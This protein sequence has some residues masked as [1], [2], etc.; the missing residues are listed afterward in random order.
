MV[1]RSSG[2][3]EVG[4]LRDSALAGLVGMPYFSFPVRSPDRFPC[5]VILFLFPS[6]NT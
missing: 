5:F 6:M 1:L 3:V 2:P 4:I